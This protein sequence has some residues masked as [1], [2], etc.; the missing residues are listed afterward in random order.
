VNRRNLNT[1]C[2]YNAG[3][4]ALSGCAPGYELLA[5]AIQ[6]SKDVVGG[7]V[8]RRG[9]VCGA[10]SAA[11]LS[12]R[13]TAAQMLLHVPRAGRHANRGNAARFAR[14]GESDRAVV[15]RPKWRLSRDNSGT[16][17][18]VHHTIYNNT[19]TDGES[20]GRITRSRSSR[21]HAADADDVVCGARLLPRSFPGLSFSFARRYRQPD[22]QFWAPVLVIVD[23]R[24]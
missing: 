10:F 24:Q 17:L 18:F 21:G 12:R 13:S 2:A 14:S 6:T 8:G 7:F 4:G 5:L 9:V 11:I 19:G 22:S 1:W 15:P 16:Y 23:S 20:D 3:E